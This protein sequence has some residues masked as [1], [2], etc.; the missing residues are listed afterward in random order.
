MSLLPFYTT[1]RS[2]RVAGAN[3][4]SA[5]ISTIDCARNHIPWF[6]QVHHRLGN[7]EK[8]Q[9]RYDD[10]LVSMLWGLPHFCYEKSPCG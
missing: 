6:D 3:C 1:I 7:Q 9:I 5:P 8:T 4:R 2:F 10:G